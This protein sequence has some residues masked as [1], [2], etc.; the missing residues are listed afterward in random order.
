MFAIVAKFLQITQFTIDNW[1]KSSHFARVGRR[2]VARI[3]QECC[4]I[5]QKICKN[6]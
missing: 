4:K 1:E 5:L 2:S 3:L 6:F